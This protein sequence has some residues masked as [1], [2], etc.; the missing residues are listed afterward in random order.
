MSYCRLCQKSSTTGIH[1]SDGGMIYFVFLTM[2]FCCFQ[3][4]ELYAQNNTSI[5]EFVAR[6]PD[7]PSIRQLAEQGDVE[8]QISLGG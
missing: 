4:V 1:L 8:A 3:T 5:A 6:M 2:V 7:A